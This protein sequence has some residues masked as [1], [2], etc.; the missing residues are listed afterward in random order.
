MVN[1]SRLA[2]VFGLCGLVHAAFSAAQH[3][4]YIRLTDQEYISLPTD[5]VV[6]IF[7]SFIAVCVGV[8]GLSGTL[9]EIEAASEFREKTWDSLGNHPS[10]YIFHHRR[11][12]C[13]SQTTH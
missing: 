13:L 1:V 8:V 3:R 11:L 2:L 5:I 10:F 4:S 12:P 9:K 6:Q 7:L